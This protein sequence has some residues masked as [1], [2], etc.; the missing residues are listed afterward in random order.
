MTP[1]DQPPAHPPPHSW[2]GLTGEERASARRELLVSSARRI[3]AGKGVGAL[4]IRAIA[5]GAQ[6][7]TRYFY[8]SFE[9]VDELLG[10]A[11][12]QLHMELSSRLVAGAE[13]VVDPSTLI[14]LG[15]RT[16]LEFIEASPERAC[17][18]FTEGLS[19]PTLVE[20]R[21]RAQDLLI[22]VVRDDSDVIAPMFA[23]AMSQLV[24][25]WVG[26]EI[27]G[28]AEEVA[29]RAAERIER[30]FDLDNGAGSDFDQ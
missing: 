16:V 3:L 4:S 14:R 7:N 18:L 10:Y 15:I 12:D 1:L 22:Q 9:S 11:Y 26:G 28:T 13:G 20:R 17:V 19:N 29:L 8:E 23:A 24:V 5:S 6:L 30:I 27:E 2:R 25:H 21:R